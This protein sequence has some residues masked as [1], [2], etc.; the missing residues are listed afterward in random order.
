MEAERPTAKRR[1]VTR[2]SAADRER[3]I[4]EQ[5]DSGMS[6]TAFCAQRGVN[7]STFHGWAKRRRNGKVRE[8]MFAQGQV[9]VAAEAA[10]VEVLL[11]NGVRIA[12]RHPGRCEEL[13]SLIRG[14][15]GVCEAQ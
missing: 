10:A 9:V 1:V 15:A 8:P 14:V 5:A 4:A 13:V 12:I 3:L 2:Y 11:P 7:L 6:K